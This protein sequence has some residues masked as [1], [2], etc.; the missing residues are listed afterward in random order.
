M[1]IFERIIYICASI[2]F[3]IIFLIACFSNKTGAAS[4]IIVIAIYILSKRYLKINLNKYIKKYFPIILF[5]FA[6]ILRYAF[7]KILDITPYSDFAVLLNATENLKD[8]VN[9]M[10]GDA[11]FER[12]GYNV[13]YVLYQILILKV[14]NSVEVIHFLDCVYTAGICVLIYYIGK[15]SF[16]KEHICTSAY[17]NSIDILS[18]RSAA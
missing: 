11:Y 7:V 6:F 5:I 10:L 15:K 16:K 1:R 14:F 3:G 13:I 2:L 9:V 17:S 4:A 8:G 18:Y 12:W